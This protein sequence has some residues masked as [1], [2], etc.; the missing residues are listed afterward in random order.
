MNK[1][2]CFL[3]ALCATLF[4]SSVSAQAQGHHIHFSLHNESGKDFTKVYISPSHEDFWTR[5]LLTEHLHEED[6]ATISY[7]PKGDYHEWDLKLVDEEGHELIFR[8]LR[9]GEIRSGVLIRENGRI[10]LSTKKKG[11]GGG[12]P[13]PREP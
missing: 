12:G 9:L 1:S 5:N 11:D 8:D 10:R 13:P 7:T 6:T 4:F 2:L 3:A